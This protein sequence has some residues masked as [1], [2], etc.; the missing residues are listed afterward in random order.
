MDDSEIE[1]PWVSLNRKVSGLGVFA[2]MSALEMGNH[3]RC[4]A[5]PPC[6]ECFAGQSIAHMASRALASCL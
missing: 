4:R 6:K 1:V 2:L 5:P 3:A